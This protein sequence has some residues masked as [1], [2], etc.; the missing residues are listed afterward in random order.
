MKDLKYNERVRDTCAV[1]SLICKCNFLDEK[2]F[3]IFILKV[4]IACLWI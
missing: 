1:E 4:Y 2:I 3:D